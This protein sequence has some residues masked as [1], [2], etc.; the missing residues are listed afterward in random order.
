MSEIK[1]YQNIKEYKQYYYL[2][3]KKKYSI[4]SKKNHE[5]YLKKNV[6]CEACKRDYNQI[7]FWKHSKTKKH[8]KNLEKYNK[9]QYI[10]TASHNNVKIGKYHESP[11]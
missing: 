2:K 4:N 10:I 5:K 11:L 1:T 8:K 6:T 3:N 9:I 7:Q